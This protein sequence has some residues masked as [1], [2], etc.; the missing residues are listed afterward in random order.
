MCFCVVA[1]Q[2]E[3]ISRKQETSQ[4]AGCGGSY[5]F[6]MNSTV[7]VGGHVSVAGGVMS[8]F[9][10]AKAIGANFFQIFTGS[11]RIWRGSETTDAI[12]EKFRAELF[13]G[14]SGVK[15]FV[16]HAS[17][18]INLATSDS[19]LLEKSVSLLSDNVKSASKLGAAGI[20]LHVGSH[21]GVGLDATLGTIGESLAKVMSVCDGPIRILLENTA[22]AGGSVGKSFEELARVIEAI[23]GDARVGVCI[24]TQHLFAS[25]MTYATMA[26]ADAVVDRF[27]KVLGLE[28]LG[29]VHLNDSKAG[30]GSLRDR[31]ENLGEGLIGSEALGNIISHP[32]LTGVPLVLE[33]P[34]A[35]AGPRSHDVETA[36]AILRDGIQ[37]RQ[38]I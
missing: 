9:E 16:T 7:L 24:D 3:K 4:H 17:Y 15:G 32:K 27:M 26:D 18:L 35:G 22:G 6:S 8:A 13:T 25:G 14:Q 20:V 21:K 11:P 29:C 33:T 23:N 34:G 31:H 5:Y 1:R 37:R 10:N 19:E 12:A 28:R 2:F 36:K 38:A 30:P